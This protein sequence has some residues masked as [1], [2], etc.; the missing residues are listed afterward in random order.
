MH[1]C[2]VTSRKRVHETMPAKCRWLINIPEIIER[3][4][5]L[6][7]PVIDR[8]I[9]ERTFEV[10]RRRAIDLMKRFGGGFESGNVG[11]L[12]RLEVIRQLKQIA[13][14]DEVAQEC[15]RRERLAERIDEASR[16]R[17]AARVRIPIS[18]QAMDRSFPVLPD[19]VCLSDG[20][21]VAEYTTAE[22]L[23][24]RLFEVAQAA[25]NNYE[26]FRATVEASVPANAAG[27]KSKSAA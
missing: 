10:R 1:E 4:S 12:D 22:Q 23:L 9:F 15:Q 17:S 20:K 18:P 21:L 8:V 25:A 6:D 7:V 14:G 3:L 16:Y 11:F 2:A 26:A 19:G 5:R 13:A 24:Q 27:G